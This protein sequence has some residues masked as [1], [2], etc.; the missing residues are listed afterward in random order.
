M[1]LQ[2]LAPALHATIPPDTLEAIRRYARQ[3]CPVGDFLTAV[4]SND[5]MAAVG[6]ADETNLA[7]LPAICHYVHWEI[8]ARC[9]GSRAAVEAWLN[10]PQHGDSGT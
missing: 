1:T 8:P 10:L 9:H 6:R 3:H 7:A 5:L 2:T 4:L